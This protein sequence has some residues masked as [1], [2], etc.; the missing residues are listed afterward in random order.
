MKHLVAQSYLTWIRG[1]QNTYIYSAELANLAS[2]KY[3][4]KF[5]S[6]S[7][8]WHLQ[9]AVILLLHSLS[10]LVVLG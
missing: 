8:I 1:R 7:I 2:E 10:R 4:H 9:S 5:N 3:K 6:K